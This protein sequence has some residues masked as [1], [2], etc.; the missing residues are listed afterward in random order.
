MTDHIQTPPG[1]TDAPIEPDTAVGAYTNCDCSDC[2]ERRLLD[3]RN[4][5]YTPHDMADAFTQGHI[6]GWAAA[7]RHSALQDDA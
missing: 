4:A 3:D 5:F 6:S 7:K 2:R 1:E